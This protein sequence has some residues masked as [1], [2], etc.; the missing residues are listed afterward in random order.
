V[1]NVMMFE[2]NRT[3]SHKEVIQKDGTKITPYR[4]CSRTVTKSM[5]VIFKNRAT[6]MTC[7]VSGKM[8]RASEKV[9]R[10]TTMHH[11]PTK[12]VA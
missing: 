2:S 3:I 11:Q 1:L 9:C 4:P 10:V 12:F 8:F 6:P 7:R 5:H